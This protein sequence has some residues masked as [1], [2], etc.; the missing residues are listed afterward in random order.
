MIKQYILNYD[1][2]NINKFTS[3]LGPNRTTS[4]E[5]NYLRNV[6]L[7]LDVQYTFHSVTSMCKLEKYA[8]A[9]NLNKHII[10]RIVEQQLE[11]PSRFSADL[12][13]TRHL[14]FMQ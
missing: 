9:A 12:S 1:S 6:L 4:C 8:E 11:R 2:T 5:V 13:S 14:L 3:L 7:Q 10:R